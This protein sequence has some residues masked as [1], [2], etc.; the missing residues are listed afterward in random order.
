MLLGRCN[1]PFGPGATCYANDLRLTKTV[2]KRDC[3]AYH[4]GGSGAGGGLPSRF[5]NSRLPSPTG[6]FTREQSVPVSNP[7][8][9]GIE[10]SIHQRAS[11]SR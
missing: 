5:Q 6:F 9:E 2:S 3:S 11:L 10:R 4:G 7:D 8:S 1:Q